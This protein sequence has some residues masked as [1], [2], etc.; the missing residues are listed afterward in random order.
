MISRKRHQF[1]LE[2]E[3]L[4][5][6]KVPAPLVVAGGGLVNVAANVG[7]VL[8]RN[9]VDISDVVSQNNIQV[10]VLSTLLGRQTQ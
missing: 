1:S 10:A 5:G 6:R 7:D 4:E 8:S 9:D 3:S 2:L